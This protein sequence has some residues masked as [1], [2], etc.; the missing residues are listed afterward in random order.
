MTRKIALPDLRRRGRLRAARR[1]R[2]MELAGGSLDHLIPGHD[3]LVLAC[4]PTRKRHRARGP[5]AADADRGARNDDRSDFSASGAWAR[6]WRRD[7]LGHVDTLL[8]H[9]LSPDA[10]DD[11][12]REGRRGRRLG[13]GAGR[14]LR[15]RVHEPADPADR[16]RGGRPRSS[17]GGSPRIVCDLSTSGPQLAQELHDLLTPRGIASFDAPVSG[18]I[19]GAE[20]GT[21]AIM[22]GG[23]EAQWRR[24]RAAARRASASRS[25]WARR[26][27][28]GRSP[29]SPT[30]C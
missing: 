29:S 16:A 4:F 20:Q 23:P 24:A 10:V 6:R 30:T 3:P 11:A 18:G 26:P 8:V 9:D 15:H 17:A 19:R 14:T 13:R 25:T 22:V 7:L 28:P 12:G 2:V 5:A 1:Q 21:L 27:A